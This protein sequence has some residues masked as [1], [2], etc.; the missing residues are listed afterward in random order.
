MEHNFDYCSTVWDGVSLT[1]LDKIQKLQNRVA[2][3]IT[4]GRNGPNACQLS[5]KLEAIC[6]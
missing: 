5:V 6:Q 2:R 1:L 3:V 4:E